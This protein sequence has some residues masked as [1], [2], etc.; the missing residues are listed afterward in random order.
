MIAPSSIRFQLLLSTAVAAVALPASA[1]ADPLPVPAA[2]N[3][4][5]NTSGNTETVTLTDPRTVINWNSFDIDSGYTVDFNGNSSGQAVL[6]RVVTADVS[7]I[8][9]N[10]LSDPDI[11]VF[12]INPNGIIFGSTANV[13]V[14]GLVASTLN[15]TDA[16]FLGSGGTD[17]GLD[18][19]GSTTDPNA[20]ISTGVTVQGGAQVR[21]A[22]GPLY[23]IGGSVNVDSGGIV[24]GAN[25]VGLAA[26]NWV[27]F[28]ADPGSPINFTIFRPTPVAQ[29]ITVAG[30]VSSKN[31]QAFMETDADAPDAEN[32]LLLVTDTGSITATKNGGGD[33]ILA[34]GARTGDG[35]I[36]NSPGGIRNDGTLSATG[37]ISLNGESNID[38][39]TFFW[40][41]FV[42]NNGTINAGGNVT[43]QALHDITNSGDITGD[44]ITLSAIASGTENSPSDVQIVNSGTITASGN[45]K[46]HAHESVVGATGSGTVTIFA[47]P[48]ANS[49]QHVHVTNSGTINAGGDVDLT[50]GLS[51]YSYAESNI[52][53]SPELEITNSGTINAGRDVN[54]QG[55]I[56]AFN[57]GGTSGAAA[58]ID[59]N[60][61]LAIANSGTID[62]GR[63]VNVHGGIE[64]FNL[65]AS[66]ITADANLDINNSK[67]ITAGGNVSIDASIEQFNFSAA[68][69]DA[70]AN[71][72]VANSKT[73]TAGGDVT[74]DG[75][76]ELFNF[77]G[78][79]GAATQATMDANLGLTNS[80]VITAGG[81][82]TLDASVDLFNVTASNVAASANLDITN[83]NGGKLDGDNVTLSGIV[84]AFSVPSAGEVH[85]VNAGKITAQGNVDLLANNSSASSGISLNA[86]PAASAT[87]TAAHANITNSGTIDAAGDVHLKAFD[88][89]ITNSGKISGDNVFLSALGVATAYE[90]TPDLNIRILNSGTI[91]AQNDVHLKAS[92]SVSAS[93]VTASSPAP[94]V[95]ITNKGTISAGHDVDI[96]AAVDLSGSATASDLAVPPVVRI[97]N[98]GSISAGNVVHLY[99]SDGDITNSGMI[100][101]DGAVSAFAFSGSIV[102][103][104]TIGGAGDVLLVADRNITNSGVIDIGGQAVLEAG[105]DI[106]NSG[107][108]EAKGD[109]VLSAVNNILD[110]S[111]SLAGSI[112]GADVALSAGNS[113]TVGTVN[114]R[115]DIAIR[116]RGTVTSG[117]LTSGT[118]VNGAGPIEENGAADE[119][120]SGVDLSGHDVDVDGSAIFAGVIDAIGAGSDIRLG[121][122]VSA[123]VNDLDFAAGGDITIDG[124]A[125]GVD[126]AMQA[127]GTITTGD[128]SARD[129]IALVAG[130]PLDVGILASGVTV[131]DAGP[132]DENGSADALLGQTLDGHDLF[133]QGSSV[134]LTKATANGAGSDLTLH[135]TTGEL[136]IVDGEAGGMITL[137]KE[138]S[139]GI[140]SA[141]TLLAG[142]GVVLRSDTDIE[143]QTVKTTTGDLDFAAGGDVTVDN[144][145][146]A[147]DVAINAGGTITTG[148]ISARDDIALIA[149]NTLDVGVL[150]SGVT[151]GGT[152]PVDTSGAADA[153]LGEAL[154]GH[155]LFVQGGTVNLTQAIANGTGSDLT[156]TATTGALSIADGEAGGMIT[157]IKEGTAG[158]LSAQT[159]LAGTGVVLRSDTDIQADTVQTTSGDLDFRAG[160]DVTVNSSLAAT[161]VAISAGGTIKTGDISARDDIALI[162]GN[163]LDTG[164][165]MSGVTVG[166]TGPL[167]SSGAADALLGETLGGHDLFVQGGTVNLSKAIANGT[168]SDLS[169]T[170]TNGA[171]AITDGEA[172]GTITLIKQ[173][174]VGILTAGTL[175]AGTGATLKSDTDIDAQTVQS[176]SGDLAF[177]AANDV[178][179]HSSLAGDDVAID[180][181]RNID[182]GD[183]S[184]RDDIALVAGGTLNTGTLASGVTIGG[185]GPLDSSGAAD[186]LIGS[187]LA[188]H[189]ISVQAAQV[190][191]ASATANGTGS[192]LTV[193]AKSGDL[194]VTSGTA[195][196]AITLT[197]EG[198]S[199]A[200]T[201][202]TLVAGTGASLKSDTSIR[203]D[204]VNSAAGD[205]DFDALLGV[206][207]GTITA[208]AGNVDVLANDLDILGD[209]TGNKV[210]IT[211][212]D[213]GDS[214]V[215]VLG[216]ASAPNA[217]TLTEAELNHIHAAQVDIN[218][219]GQDMLIGNVAFADDVGSTR[220]N[221][222]GTGRIDI[223]GEVSA[224]GTGRTVQ[225]G[226]TDG[227]ADPND[228]GTMASIIRIA[229]T[230]TAGGR[231]ILDGAALDLR[232]VKIGVGLDDGFLSP[233][234][235]GPG[236]TPVSTQVVQQDWIGNPNS[237]LYGIPGGYANP[238]V[239]SA[240]N[241]TVTYGDY[242]LFQNTGSRGVPSGVNA[243][244]LSIISSGNDGNGFELFGNIDNIGG[245]GAA[246]LVVPTTVSMPNS[247]VNG[248]LIVTG[249]GCGGPTEVPPTT[250]TFDP[251]DTDEVLTA[252]VGPFADQSLVS[253]D[254]EKAFDFD[255]LVGT[256]NEGLLGVLDETTE[257]EPC[258]PDDKRDICRT[259]GGSK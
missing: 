184:A 214:N 256:N 52:N 225:I 76:I 258:P 198:S 3:P 237:S 193:D 146:E 222:L 43:M 65:A 8:N 112:G 49:P 90:S 218:S 250:T 234:G 230:S 31:F 167:D 57:F 122:P 93:A 199:G 211:N 251:T 75:S 59:I 172:G 29:A 159:L 226:G 161:D 183:I 119:L 132:V 190:N 2:A 46:L 155:D 195:G 221:L 14:G 64:L 203:A 135:A 181:G 174:T 246:L 101:A 121:A 238:V 194:N 164:V 98:S 147:T 22:S 235:L 55:S 17:G 61:N 254:D 120:L 170:A 117:S 66:N 223:V 37:R 73:I 108:I 110:S 200:L 124:S 60:A 126:V 215:T 145:L 178:T 205:I 69:I 25:N 94:N 217:F 165:L 53:V 102:N 118:T 240:S 89:D 192:D 78:T 208:Q 249:G 168:G 47:L 243:G 15:I 206:T 50:A 142:T 99:A 163:T 252:E 236:G 242:A 107:S 10:L 130:G 74:L 68:H 207:L 39:G 44:N 5:I 72:Y 21:T 13:D 127:G 84:S 125:S 103:S 158:I 144:P 247:R 23:L 244:V 143:A 202:G 137:I 229:A 100:S 19:S 24:D 162:A 191:L 91:T 1:A 113:I 40:P 212:R 136:S 87:V 160:G 96:S 9:G 204:N 201:A 30:A 115:D 34:I 148:D 173:G 70:S 188:G 81:N 41:E 209:V 220:L 116:A 83:A 38:A 257:P 196:G 86:V 12:L 169:V 233:L 157:L 150:M 45:V 111:G 255:S 228:P 58:N 185:T 179:V 51:V 177:E 129:D 139:S 11:E 27:R 128:I 97:T 245:K 109:V 171:L 88:G 133:A 20:V 7:D 26:G 92:L 123:S 35:T 18:F 197:K 227:T 16:E 166:G 176:A 134:D 253:T 82:V 152:G 28:P 85:I 105:A 232:G 138:G 248:C 213:D 63:D 56:S 36:T 131:N 62:A 216:D 259:D 182:T 48:A 4:N 95:Q 219:L 154:A 156:V 153:L 104:G 106:D 80:G 42:E 77:S 141:Q 239:I 231:I 71:L 210:L 187:D 140:L 151:V 186:A 6:N 180:A 189:D 149:G 79:N 32:A 241:I 33:I 175:T 54:I 67:S 114:A 224:S